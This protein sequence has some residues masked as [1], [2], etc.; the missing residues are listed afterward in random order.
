MKHNK[1]LLAGALS[2]SMIAAP[3]M[4]AASFLPVVAAE[5][6]V[7]ITVPN[8]DDHEY[9]VY[10][11]F[12]GDLSTN[13]A[14][15]K[16]LS[17]IKWGSNGSGE[18][19]QAVANDVLEALSAVSSSTNDKDKLA[20]IEQYANLEGMLLELSAKILLYQSRQVII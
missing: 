7:N 14:G 1:F 9:S 12:V 20:V 3:M 4:S 17:N 16:V 2:L 11:I 5:G 19:G 10:Q 18:A 13:Q 15:A 8:D 6:D